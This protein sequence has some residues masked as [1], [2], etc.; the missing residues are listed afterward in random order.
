LEKDI[1]NDR[2][3]H[4]V[5]KSFGDLKNPSGRM[6]SIYGS[7]SCRGTCQA[8]AG[9][10]AC[11][12]VADRQL[13]LSL[14]LLASQTCPFIVLNSNCAGSPVSIGFTGSGYPSSLTIS[15]AN[16][17]VTPA[18]FRVSRR[19]STPKTS[20]PPPKAVLLWHSARKSNNLCHLK[21]LSGL[22]GNFINGAT[23]SQDAHLR[24]DSNTVQPVLIAQPAVLFCRNT[25]FARPSDRLPSQHQTPFQSLL[26]PLHRVNRSGA[27]GRGICWEV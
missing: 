2:L 4:Y 21:P 15:P 26:P 23:A 7:N 6:W 8:T 13:Q 19:I 17:K 14:L 5:K 1:H 22:P 10:A 12:Q 3:K 16:E 18:E 11:L 9:T 27:A 25:P 20:V 24:K